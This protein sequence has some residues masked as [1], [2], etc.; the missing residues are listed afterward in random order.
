MEG[1]SLMETER[2]EVALVDIFLPEMNGLELFHKIRSLDR[3]LPII[4][5]T[6]DN[7]SETAIEAMRIGAFDYLSKPL[8]LGQLRELTASALESRRLMDMP[9]RCR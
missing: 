1:L 8:N 6:A 7:S 5:V 3:K 4:F 2:P 9:S